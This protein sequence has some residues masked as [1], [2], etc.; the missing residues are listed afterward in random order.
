MLPPP[1]PMVLTSTIGTR[2]GY[3]AMIPSERRRGL[4][5]EISAMSELVPPTSTEMRSRSPASAPTAWAPMT[6][7][8][9]PERK[10]RT[11]R[12]RAVPAPASP[13]RDCITCRGPSTPAAAR[14]R[15][16]EER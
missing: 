6:P 12:C 5:P 8:A 7:A 14:R 10:S 9:G 16:K 11:G 15:E 4:A 3:P 13:P 2:T 1:A